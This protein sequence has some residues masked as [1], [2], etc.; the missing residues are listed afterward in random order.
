MKRDVL[1]SIGKLVRGTLATGISTLRNGRVE[2]FQTQVFCPLQSTGAYIC[3]L[4]MLGPSG[5]QHLASSLWSYG[6]SI[7]HEDL[8]FCQDNKEVTGTQIPYRASLRCRLI[9]TEVHNSWGLSQLWG[10]GMTA[11]PVCKLLCQQSSQSL[12]VEVYKFRTGFPRQTL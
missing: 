5:K 1:M 4:E 7:P 2:D 10:S 3:D 12:L 8:S 6:T 9:H 11:W